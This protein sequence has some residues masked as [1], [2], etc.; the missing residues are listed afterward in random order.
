MNLIAFVKNKYGD[1]SLEYIRRSNYASKKAFIADL[2]GNGYAIR[3]VM[4]DN[5]WR[6]WLFFIGTGGYRN[7][8]EAMRAF[9]RQQRLKKNDSKILEWA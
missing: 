1:K 7:H 3:Y 2:R 5:E 8:S 4:T 6:D 9:R